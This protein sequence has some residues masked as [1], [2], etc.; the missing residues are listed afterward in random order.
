MGGNQIF[1]AKLHIIPVSKRANTGRNRQTVIS[2]EEAKVPLGGIMLRRT[3][4]E[5][6]RQNSVTTTS[7]FPGRLKELKGGMT[8]W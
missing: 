8:V 1:L 2:M 3:M 6:G 5:T 7:A 4:K